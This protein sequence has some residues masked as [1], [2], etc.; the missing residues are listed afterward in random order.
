MKAEP[1][2]ARNA[3]LISGEDAEDECASRQAGTVDDDAFAAAAQH[4]ESLDIGSNASA[5]VAGN[6]DRCGPLGYSGA[7]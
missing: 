6:P 3:D 4:G 7:E 1:G 2:S 5:P